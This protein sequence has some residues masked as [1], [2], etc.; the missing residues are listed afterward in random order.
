MKTW[1]K[2]YTEIIEDPDQGTLSLAERGIWS[3]FLALCGRIDDRDEYGRETGKL[4]TLA[5]VAWY[6]RCDATE[7]KSAV[8]SFAMR[9]MVEEHDGVLYITN[10][11]KYGQEQ[12]P[13]PAGAVIVWRN[14]V[15]ARDK[16]TCQHCGAHGV[17]LNAHHIRPWYLY[18]NER[19]NENNGITLCK[20][21]HARM[22]KAGWKSE[23]VN[24]ALS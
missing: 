17:N 20:K 7:I 11:A 4:D 12:E 3:L 18:P 10:W 22:H 15:F 21:C 2:L 8:D 6:L 16:Y 9:G 19:F 13:R 5:R 23:A 14:A 24:A 1:V